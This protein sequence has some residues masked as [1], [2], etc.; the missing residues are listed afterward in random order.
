MNNFYNFLKS[1]IFLKLV[2]VHLISL[3]NIWA[4][5]ISW[6]LSYN[7]LYTA[8]FILPS[9]VKKL[10]KNKYKEEKIDYIFRF[11]IKDKEK[12]M[13]KGSLDLRKKINPFQIPATAFLSKNFL[14]REKDK[15]AVIHKNGDREWWFLGQLHR[16]KEPA[17]IRANGD[18]EYW[19]KH[20]L[21]LIQY[22]NGTQEWYN[23]YQLHRY[24]KPAIEYKNGDYE[25]WSHGKRHRDNGPAVKVGKKE[26]WYTDGEIIRVKN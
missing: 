10:F 6:F 3:F 5:G 2:L 16:E 14:H 20:N 7:F 13:W 15:P 11:I 24:E 4:F 21:I 23:G 1:Q 17:I 8:T 19:H 25:Y 18:K 12:T 22:A 9:A 26:V